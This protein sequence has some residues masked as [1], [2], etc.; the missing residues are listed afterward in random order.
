M[1]SI[2]FILIFIGTFGLL[3]VEFFVTEE[4]RFLTL[5]F[6]ALNL[7]GLVTLYTLVLRRKK[8]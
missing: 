7:L 4:S 5:T 2:P 3:A 1:K 6:A 8:V